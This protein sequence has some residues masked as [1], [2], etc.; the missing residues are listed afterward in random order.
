MAQ[1]EVTR[2]DWSDLV[3]VLV[4]TSLLLLS[5]IPVDADRVSGWERSVF[6]AVNDLPSVIYPVP[7]WAFM[8]LGNFLVVPVTA[9]VALLA[10]RA[11]LAATLAVA[12]VS[13]YVLAKVVKQFVERGR[14]A[15]LL[16]GTE[17]RGAPAHGLGFVSGHAAVICALAT[18]A[19]PY[20]GSRGRIVTVSLAAI[21]CFTRAYV[22]AH[23]PLDVIGGA[24]LGVAC[25]G[26]ARLIVGTPRRQSV[27]V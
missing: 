9:L 17:I 24:G 4:G 15:E 19:W 21:V 16:G 14:P 11:R 22:G 3:L 8:Q 26:L 20:L 1:A 2:R 23:L 18:A 6:R 27:P 10:R 12:G 7:V 5:A 25:G 13:T